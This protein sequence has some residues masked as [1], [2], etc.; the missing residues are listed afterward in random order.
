[1]NIDDPRSK[2]ELHALETEFTTLMNAGEIDRLVDTFYTEDVTLLP[3][4]A[5]LVKGPEAVKARFEEMAEIFSDVS[6]EPGRVYTSGDM[7][8]VQ[9]TYRA[10]LRLPDGSQTE[11]RG[12][13]IE[14]F[15]RDPGGSWRCFLDTFNSDLGPPS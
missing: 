8:V 7:A 1:M 10:T 15:R 11:D 5:P 3:P 13:Y 14:V 2:K 9:G 6:L 4:N 12:K